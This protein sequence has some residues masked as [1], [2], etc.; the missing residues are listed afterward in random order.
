MNL[1]LKAIHE[2]D[3]LQTGLGG[4]FLRHQCAQQC[5]LLLSVSFQL[6]NVSIHTLEFISELWQLFLLELHNG[7]PVKRKNIHQYQYKGIK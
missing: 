3:I 1:D 4:V 6:L 5:L 2:G 7:L